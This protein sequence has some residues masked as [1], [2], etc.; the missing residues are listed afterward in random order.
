[1]RAFKRVIRLKTF[2][3]NYSILGYQSPTEICMTHSNRP[4]KLSEEAHVTSINVGT[5]NLVEL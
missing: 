1:M 5:A 4:A 2:Y 3:S